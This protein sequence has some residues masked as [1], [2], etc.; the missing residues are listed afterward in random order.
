MIKFPNL[1]DQFDIDYAFNLYKNSTNTVYVDGVRRDRYLTSNR[2]KFILSTYNSEEFKFLWEKIKDRLEG[3]TPVDYRILMYRINC[4]IH[5]HIDGSK[6]GRPKTNCSLIIQ[7]SEHSK[8]T[9]GE[10]IV[11][12]ELIDLNPGDG[13]L[14]FYG[15]E[16]EVK[17]IKSGQRHVIN[18]RLFKEDT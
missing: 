8:Y 9:G 4:S 2:G 15:E 1:I 18:L 10:V 3:Y 17:K 7:M 5:N 11:E 6:P 13:V 14:Y 12:N 16:H